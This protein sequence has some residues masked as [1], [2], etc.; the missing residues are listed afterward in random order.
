MVD[1]LKAALALHGRFSSGTKLTS[2]E[3]AFSRDGLAFGTKA[4]TSVSGAVSKFEDHLGGVF[5]TE[6]RA[7][8]GG[9]ESDLAISG[10]EGLT[11]SQRRGGHDE[12]LVFLRRGECASV[13]RM[14]FP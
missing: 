13:K 3:D 12:C 9:V 7:S 5:L 1:T 8:C 10:H 2:L 4:N 14:S 11:C 6:G